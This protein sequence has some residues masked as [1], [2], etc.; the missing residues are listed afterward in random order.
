[1][2]DIQSKELR[3]QFD[4]IVDK[5]VNKLLYMWSDYDGEDPSFDPSYGYWAGDDRTGVYC[6]AEQFHVSL[7]DIIFCVEKEVGYEEYMEWQDYCVECNEWGFDQ[8]NLPSWHLGCPRVPAETF[9]TLREKKENLK[10]L[11]EIVK[12]HPN[13]QI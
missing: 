4:E 12:Q 2:N 10:S 6:Y 3:K 5:Y 9:D 7:S 11:V 1:M 8:P 13:V